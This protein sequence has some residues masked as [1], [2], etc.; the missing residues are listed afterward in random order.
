MFVGHFAVGF[1][2][3]RVAPRLP[4]A[5]LFAAV[6]FLDIL[7]P[8]FILT[9]LERSR[10]VPGITAA[11][12]LD[13]YDIPYSHSLLTSLIWSA[14]FALPFYV[15]RRFREGVILSIAVFSHFVLDFVTHRPD[16]PLAPGSG[17]R[18]G[19]GLWNHRG[20]A[21]AIEAA[22]FVGALGYYL[23][24]T[25]AVGRMGTVGLGALVVV[26]LA[27]WLSGVF[28]PPPPSIGV[29]AWSALVFTP[30]IFVWG[31]AVDRARPPRR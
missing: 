29:V 3:K 20:P 8:I 26:L 24:G 4:L 10:I 30:I 21:V 7:W 9:G 31:Y 19:L 13:L 1:A 12:P 18:L 11:S 2:A 17:Q 6:C 28:G 23:R 25:R 22:L 14:L 5:L 16:L 15:G 27:A